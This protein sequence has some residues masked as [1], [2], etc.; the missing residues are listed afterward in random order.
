MAA[1]GTKNRLHRHW[2]RNPCSLMLPSYERN[3]CNSTKNEKKC[4][5]LVTPSHRLFQNVLSKS[6]WATSLLYFFPHFIYL[7]KSMMP[8]MY[9][10]ELG[11]FVVPYPVA[12]RRRV[13]RGLRCE[14]ET[15]CLRSAAA[16]GAS[17]RR[18]TFPTE[19][20]SARRCRVPSG[21]VRNLRY[22]SS[23]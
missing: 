20:S 22:Y 15:P 3:L 23:Y 4:L 19:V 1:D 16:R 2:A 5:V 14:A 9:E 8:S 12:A 10:F 17:P 21:E 18:H 7:R 11:Y 13:S 6:N